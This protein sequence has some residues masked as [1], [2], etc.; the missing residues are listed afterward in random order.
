M[1]THKRAKRFGIGLTLLL[2]VMVIGFAIANALIPNWGST[3]EEQALTLPGDEIFSS[4]VLK[5]SHAMTI[6]ATVEEVWPWIAQMGDT[7]GGYYSYRFIEKAITAVTG[8]DSSTYY[9]NTNDIHPEWQQPEIGQGMIMDSLVLRDIQPQ[10]Y[11]VAGPP[12]EMSE[13][14]LLW[15]WAVKPA[16]EGKT[17]LL[18]HMRIQIPGAGDN[19][20]VEAAFN[21]ATFMMERKMMDG[22]KLR[23]EGGSEAD[24][25]Q[26]AEAVTWFTVLITGL[27]A[28]RRYLYQEEWKRPLSIGLAAVVILFCLVYLQPALW[29]RFGAVIGLIGSMIWDTSTGNIRAQDAAALPAR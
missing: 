16:P 5:W 4:P 13:G 28:A 21:L 3:A 26:T 14:G 27:I 12:P 25:V 17:R 23:A 11:M 2:M 7:R 10:N 15:T 8:A 29:A 24:W 20:A 22:I 1:K 19:K 18:V 6:D 9:P